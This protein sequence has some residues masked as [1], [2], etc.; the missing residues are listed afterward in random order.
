MKHF[1]SKARN[2][3]ALAID[4]RADILDLL[5]GAPP[6]D[7]ETVG[8]AIVVHV[9]G[10]LEQRANPR[11]PNPEKDGYYGDSYEQIRT[12]FTAA[13][14]EEPEAIIL[15]I[16]S[17]GGV[18]AG[19]TQF[20]DALTAAKEASG[21]PVYAYA[22]ELIASAAYALACVADEIITP[23]SGI[24]GSI[25]VIALLCDQVEADKKAGLNF[26][27]ITSG[28]RKDDGHP[29]TSISED[30]IA[31][32]AKRVD[33]LAEQFFDLVRRARGFD[34]AP[35]EAGVFTGDEAVDVG[36]ADYVMGWDDV[37]AQFALAEGGT[38]VSAS[39]SVAQPGTTAKGRDML[40]LKNLIAAKRAALKSAKGTARASLNAEI[41]SLEFALASLKSAAPK[42]A[43]KKTTKTE[44][45]EE[46]TD[47]EE[48][49]GDEDAEHEE[50]DGDEKESAKDDESAEDAE[51]DDEGEDAESEESEEDAEDEA[52]KKDA[53]RGQSAAL[54]EKAEAHDRLAAE[55][56]QL[57]AAE[58]KREKAALID[59]ALT[60]RRITKAHAKMLRTEKLS[61]VK[62]FLKMH[63]KAL[64]QVE[65]EELLPDGSGLDAA[66]PGGR[67]TEQQMDM[68][69]KAAAASGGTLTVDKL[70]E[71]Y[72]KNPN[73]VNGI[74][75][76][77]G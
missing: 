35:L 31:A 17:P 11:G 4:R 27:T 7:N 73:P 59:A 21:I 2:H 30:A 74:A 22:D 49:D 18:V 15:R 1:R 40:K 58:V 23:A 63:T 26:V 51:G 56:A 60:G 55:V 14:A 42:A 52:P 68:F 6:R 32:E 20:V 75:G 61:F 28:A 48:P 8:S 12:R 50:P 71:N 5:M 16:D 37:V 66:L 69:R 3:E 34:P 36:V 9:N 53:R 47:D 13:L 54:R 33:A 72:R 39:P 70:I 45:K 25:G 19:L 77:V 76:K 41:A 38:R 10:P 57:R 67:I 64:Y 24:V 46:K 65:G 29:H 43:Y 62:G 44:T